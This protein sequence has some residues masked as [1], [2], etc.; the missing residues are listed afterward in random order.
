[1]TSTR[2]NAQPLPCEPC[3]KAKV[4]CDNTIPQCQNCTRRG[5]GDNCVYV[6]AP[7][8]RTWY[9]DNAPSPTAS[10]RPQPRPDSALQSGPLPSGDEKLS[11]DFTNNSAV[12]SDI[13][14]QFKRSLVIDT[15][16]AARPDPKQIQLG[17]RLLALLFDNFPLYERLAE[18]SVEVWPEGCV[19]GHRLIS[20][21]F[22]ALDDLHGALTSDPNNTKDLQSSLLRWSQKIFD[23]SAKPL[24]V[25]PAMSPEDYIRRISGRWE[26]IGLVFTVVGQGAMLERDW[27]SVRANEGN[28]PRDQKALAAQAI[29]GSDA[30]LQF[31]DLSGAV[32]DSLGWLLFQHIHLLTLVS[33]ENDP[34]AWR[35]LADLSTTVFTLSHNPPED[36]RIPFFLLELRKRLIAG[37]YSIDK[38]LATFLGRPPQISW[39]YYD[40]QF[41]LDLSYDEILA[42][43]KVRET[44]IS[45]LDKTGW[46][47]QGI[48]GQAA[49]M[50]IA[51]LIGSTREQ[52]LELSLSRRIE[53]LPRKVQ[54][55]SQQSHKTWNDLPGFLRWRPGDSD[56][57]DSSVLVPLYLNFLYNDFLLYRV[58]VRRSQSGSEGLISVSQNILGTI[59]ELIGKEIGSR[60]GTYNVG[61]NASSF[62]VPAAGVLAIELLCQS[63][64]QSQ[65]PPS[66]FRRSEVIQKLT[67]FASHLQ[68]VVRPHD[69]MYDVCQRARKVISNILDRIL[70]VN[71]PPLPA[72][73]PADVLATNWL[74]GE[75]VV[76]D[77]GT[78]LFRWLDGHYSDASRRG[79]WA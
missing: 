40:V 26:G 33:G 35:R 52:I 32:N 45:Q 62:G 41:P 72:S 36:K 24:A 47:T 61:W 29:S 17:A 77:D 73:L 55:V 68:Y 4:R 16:T 69:G 67:V 46:N 63:E 25:H 49:W 9:S 71:P 76:L 38:Q 19:L 64:S 65:L 66:T 56:S 20:G 28:V 3:R 74:N 27:R 50:R 53:E 14:D 10:P 5:K 7:V 75:T 60:T 6:S 39:R 79:S 12:F 11:V 43:P 42:E 8:T 22:E 37:A 30:C 21:M 59:L 48:V 70:T 18:T 31:C 54:E 58:L 13:G 44:A 51:L 78:D 2:R 1:M 15:P 34:R 23:D 57:N